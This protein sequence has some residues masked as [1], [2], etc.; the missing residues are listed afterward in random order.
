MRNREA[1]LMLG[2]R[3]LEVPVWGRVDKKKLIHMRRKFHCATY[4]A[5]NPELPIQPFTLL[6]YANTRIDG[7]RL[8]A[9]RKVSIG[10]PVVHKFFKFQSQDRGHSRELLN[11]RLN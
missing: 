11:R 4:V 6:K 5:V 10:R 1:V 9:E 7:P 3:L 2:F 8:Q